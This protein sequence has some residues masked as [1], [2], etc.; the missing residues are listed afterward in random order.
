MAIQQSPAKRSET[1][2]RRWDPFKE[3]RQEMA[4]CWGSSWPAFPWALAAGQRRGESG[5][6]WAPSMDVYEK[7]NQLIIKAELPGVKK[8]DVEVTLDDGGLLIRG[9]RKAEHEVKED[10]YYR[11]ERSYGS[12]QRRV[13]LPFEVKPEQVIGSFKDGVLELR[14]PRPAE[15]KPAGQQIRIT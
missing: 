5:T 3:L 8:E 14:I 4:R 10:H 2:L 13:P 11:M 12:F 9:E 6:A 7:D 15:S 1:Q